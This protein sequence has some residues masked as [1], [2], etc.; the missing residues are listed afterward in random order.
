MGLRGIDHFELVVSD[1]DRAVSFYRQLGLESVEST[2]PGSGRRR[3]FLNVGDSQQ[4][5]VVTP[6][7]VETLGRASAAGGGHLCMVWEGKAEEV[8]DQLSRNGLIARRTRPGL[9]RTWRGDKS[10]HQ[11]PRFKLN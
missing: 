8:V 6:Q 7:D 11:R 9:G 10:V 2:A 4:V 5:N 1:V 3:V